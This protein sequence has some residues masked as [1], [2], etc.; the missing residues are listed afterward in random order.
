M[1]LTPMPRLCD[2]LMRWSANALEAYLIRYFHNR[3]P[4]ELI[5][6]R[7]KPT[8]EKHRWA[9]SIPNIPKCK[10][11]KMRYKAIVD[12]YDRKRVPKT[13]TA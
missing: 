12:N 7:D 11:T 5:N 1:S 3:Q 6:R 13:V 4:G 9:F 2:G 10:I 8:T